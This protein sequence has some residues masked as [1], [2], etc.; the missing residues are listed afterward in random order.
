MAEGSTIAEQIADINASKAAIAGAIA[1]KGVTV[2]AGTKLGGL[3]ALVGQIDGGG[4]VS[5]DLSVWSLDRNTTT[6]LEVPE[7]ITHIGW[8]AFGNCPELLTLTLPSTLR[9]IGGVA[10]YN[11]QSL[12]ALEIPE[13]VT[14]IGGGAFNGCYGLAKLRVPASMVTLGTVVTFSGCPT[15][16]D[17]YFAKTMAQVRAMLNYPWGIQKG[18]TIHCTDGD[19]VVGA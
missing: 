15:T 2:P 19:L 12:T 1:A 10:F 8:S 6:A 3:A 7:G 9:T 16:C 5:A 13:G 4:D 18:A 17:I 11:C 14:E